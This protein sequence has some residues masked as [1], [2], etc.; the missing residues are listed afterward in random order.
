MKKTH[1]FFIELSE[2]DC[3]NVFT[4]AANTHHTHFIKDSDLN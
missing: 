1:M 3:N 2:D 4:K